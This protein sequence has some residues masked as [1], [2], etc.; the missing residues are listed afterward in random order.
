MA[1]DPLNL[2]K[3]PRSSP[4]ADMWPDIAAALD[5]PQRKPRLSWIPVAAAAT[6][7]IAVVWAG[8]MYPDRNGPAP[9]TRADTELALARAESAS[10]EE[11]LRRQRNGVLDASAVESLT[12]MEQE[13]GWLDVQLADSPTDATLWQ[14]RGDLLAEMTALYERNSWRAEIQLASY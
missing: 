3:L 2:G 7:A 14:Q 12:W 13:L 4:P 1:N 10:M 6:L 8:I 5:R 9:V 11:I